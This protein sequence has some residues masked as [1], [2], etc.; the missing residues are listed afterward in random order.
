[1]IVIIL[2]VLSTPKEDNK[3]EEETIHNFDKVR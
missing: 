1:M 3:L 2:G